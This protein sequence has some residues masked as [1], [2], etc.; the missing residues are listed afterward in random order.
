M[1]EAWGVGG[2]GRSSMRTVQRQ[3]GRGGP[4]EREHHRSC[5]RVHARA[6][7]ATWPLVAWSLVWSLSRVGMR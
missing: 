5:G 3:W 2:A 6:C 1:E 7:C 4:S